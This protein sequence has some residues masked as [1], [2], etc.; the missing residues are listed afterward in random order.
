M[1][2]RVALFVAAAVLSAA[3][4]GWSAPAPSQPVYTNK[5]RFRIPYKYDPAEMQKLG[6]REIR[7]YLS[8]DQ[9][10]QWQLAQSVD[11]RAQRFEFEAPVEG[12]Y[13]FAVRTLD[14]QNNLH[15]P[16]NTMEPGLKVVV[17]MTQPA[18]DLSLRQLDAGRVELTWTAQD[19]H[20]DLTTLRLEYMQTGAGNWQPISVVP[21]PSGQTQWAVPAGS[22]VAVRGSIADLAGNTRSA[23]ARLQAGA[24]APTG[25][26]PPT[27]DFREPIATAPQGDLAA[28]LSLPQRFPTP[29]ADPSALVPQTIPQGNHAA[30]MMTNVSDA[31]NRAE[32]IHARRPDMAATVPG[33]VAGTGGR[34]VNTRKFQI[35]YAVDEVGPSG[36]Q[37]VEMYIT[38]DGGRKWFKYGNDPDVQSPFTVEVPR[39]GMY[40]FTIRVRSGV[41]LAADPPYPGDRPAVVVTVD[42]T[43]PSIALMPPQ[44]GQGAALNRILLRWKVTEDNPADQPILLSYAADPNG[45]W[46]PIGSWQADAGSYVWTVGPGTPSRLFVRLTARDAAGNVNATETPQPVLVDLTRPT[47]RIV[48]VEAV[49]TVGR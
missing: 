24:G 40:G 44:Q 45:P 9:G 10:G 12:H 23:D 21:Q 5:P 47:A 46:T 25:P 42:S 8:T 30:P 37:S 43:P 39:D 1:K 31:G 19:P 18:F 20:L 27:P 49:G 29:A 26:A 35:G 15:P 13:W 34:V 7:L 28:G 38:E 41:G 11:P 2:H 3:S 17:D 33:P 22:V 48:D 6:A 36:V 4:E 32:I 14:G 16:G